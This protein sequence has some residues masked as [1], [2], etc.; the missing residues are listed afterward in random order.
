MVFN[1][2]CKINEPLLHGHIAYA[3]I[4]NYS[5][6][7]DTLYNIIFSLFSPCQQQYLTWFDYNVF[8]KAHEVY[9]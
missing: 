6:E 5:W 3:F 9:A 2:N 8:M 4:L 7:N 1:K